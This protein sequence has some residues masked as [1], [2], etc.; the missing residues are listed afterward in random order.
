MTWLLRTQTRLCTEYLLEGVP[1]QDMLVMKEREKDWADGDGDSVD[2]NASR[3]IES[4][5]TLR[6][7]AK[8]L[9]RLPRVDSRSALDVVL[10]QLVI[11][12]QDKKNH[13]GQLIS[14]FLASG[15]TRILAH[16]RHS[17]ARANLLGC[18]LETPLSPDAIDI[19]V[20]TLHVPPGGISSP[21]IDE[22]DH[23]RASSLS[24]GG[25]ISPP[26]STSSKEDNVTDESLTKRLVEVFPPR[27]PFEL[28]DC[29]LTLEDYPKWTAPK[30]DTPNIVRRYK[31][32]LLDNELVCRVL[33]AVIRN[34]REQW[35][36]KAKLVYQLG[37]QKERIDLR[38]VLEATK[39]AEQTIVKESSGASAAHAAPEINRYHG[40][41]GRY[42]HIVR[43]GRRTGYSA[44]LLT[45]L[46]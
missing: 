2:I 13:P 9:E 28:E 37:R 40:T 15:V 45:T 14:A 1:T 17:S 34:T 11:G 21:A 20:L 31:Q 44:T 16:A 36:N 12:G 19:V 46:C 38:K 7:I 18:P 26:M 33:T 42:A 22:D 25:C 24:S 23:L 3:N 4:I 35:L 8:M 6:Q 10:T 29:I 43:L 41:I 27:K 30:Y 39:C 32:I 5:A